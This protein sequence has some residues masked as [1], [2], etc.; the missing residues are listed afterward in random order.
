MLPSWDNEGVDTFCPVALKS[1]FQMVDHSSW[2][3][4]L[5]VE[6]AGDD[7]I[8]HAGAAAPRSI[9][10]RMGL[11]SALSRALARPGFVPV[12]DR[13]RVLADTAVLIA[14]GSRVLPDLATLRDQTQ[15]F[16]PVAS[17]PTLWR[18]LDE[19]GEIQRGRIARARAATRE[20]A[21]S[22]IEKPHGRIPPSRVADQDLGKTIVIGDGR[23]AGDRAL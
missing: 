23:L 13:G 11:T 7:V 4:D 15:L 3:K 6:I 2:S 16:A 17:D 9:A 12:H 8:N 14:D 19:V 5:T 21:W 20:H 22:L 1:I 10:D 18:A